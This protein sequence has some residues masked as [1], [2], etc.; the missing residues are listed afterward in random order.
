MIG[1]QSGSIATDARGSEPMAGDESG[2]PV[3]RILCEFKSMFGSIADEGKASMAG[4][5]HPSM[6]GATGSEL[7][8]EA[9]ACAIS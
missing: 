3:T 6:D 9:A 5:I 7:R 2:V 1:A 4:S 8:V